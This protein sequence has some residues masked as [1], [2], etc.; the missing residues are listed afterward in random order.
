[1][2]SAS[3]SLEICRAAVVKNEIAFGGGTLLCNR[4]LTSF[5]CYCAPQLLRFIGSQIDSHPIPLKFYFSEARS[6]E[7]R[8]RNLPL[9]IGLKISN[10]MHC[11]YLD[12]NV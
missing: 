9:L 5:N 1:M 8:Y 4:I 3:H 7:M 12:V 10:V 2:P 6:I 11:K